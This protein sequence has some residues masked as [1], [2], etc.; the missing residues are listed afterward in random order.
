VAPDL[1]LVAVAGAAADDL[2]AALGVPIAKAIDLATPAGF[3]RA[4]AALAARLRRLTASTE[5]D[6]VRE[7]IAVLD[8]DWRR[9]T[10]AQRRLLVAESL[11]RAGRAT[12]LIPRQ[13]R[14]PLGDAAEQV[15]TATR[16]AARRRGLAI[17]AELGALDRRVARHI[18]RSQGNF[19]RDEYGRRLDAFGAEA[20]RVVAAGLEQGLGQ[21]DLAADLERAARVALIQRAPFY[22]ETVASSFVGRGRT[23]ANLASFAEAGIERWVFE[24]VRDEATTAICRFMH[25]RVFEVQGSL[26][27]F[28]TV[29][30][31]DEPEDIKRVA[32]WVR[33]R[34]DARTGRTMLYV[35]HR[36]GRVD[37]AE[38]VR[39]GVGIRDDEGEFHARVGDNDLARLAGAPPL[40]AHCRSTQV[41][42]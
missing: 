12:A 39:S 17:G 35:N 29:E 34:R 31:L 11:Q 6:A 24:A 20:R 41:P 38:V 27:H 9:T 18:V 42:F 32:P 7:A 30:Q 25:G 26:K 8:L 2:L 36:S 5:A 22:W 4:A 37:L 1:G 15:V 23:F 14:A 28:E 21:A 40:H 33:E 16:S 10:P 3:D 13:I 19:V